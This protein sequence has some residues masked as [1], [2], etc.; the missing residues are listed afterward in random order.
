MHKV[1]IITHSSDNQSIDVVTQA[2]ASKGALAIRFNTDE[3]PLN[4]KLHCE[5]V[6]NEWNM[7]L[8]TQEHKLN[9]SEVQS[10][11]YR[12]FNPAGKLK[13]LVEEKYLS[14][15]ITES[16]RSILGMLASIDA[17]ILDD[18]HTIR[19]AGQ[20]HLQ[21]KVASSIGLTIPATAMTNCPQSTAAFYQAVN[22]QMITKMQTSFAIYE[23]GI[24]N[25]VFTNKVT[26]DEMA[27]IEDLQYCPMTFQQN[28]EKNLE[29]RVTIVGDKVF[30]ASIDS[31]AVKAAQSD[32]RKRGH[33]FQNS[34]KPY[35]LPLDISSKLLKLMDILQLNYGAID[36]IVTPDNQYVFLE[37]NPSGEFFWL[38]IFNP[39]FPIADAIA[40]VLLNN[41]FRREPQSLT[42]NLSNTTTLQ[43]G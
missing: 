9:L 20:K 4:V 40:D 29:L 23:N 1:L 17:F 10:V 5:Y 18:Y 26:D 43:N 41:S 11:W 19:R 15:S 34:W 14:P 24:E 13:G 31:Q 6:N 21:L 35:N 7:Q 37:I 30:A 28:I 22:K 38:E 2:L 33:M 3:Y 27:T 25:V 36:L 32:W 39:H 42:K 16:K 12:R 8:V